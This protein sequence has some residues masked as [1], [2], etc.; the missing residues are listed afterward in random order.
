MTEKEAKEIIKK[1]EEYLDNAEMSNDHFISIIGSKD[2]IENITT[3]LEIIY[4][5]PEYIRNTLL[6]FPIKIGAIAGRKI[7]F[8]VSDK[9]EDNSIYINVYSIEGEKE[10]QRLANDYT[11][12]YNLKG[13]YTYE[14]KKWND[15]KM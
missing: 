1:I 12:D 15:N 4:Q 2:I 14:T 11:D 7:N 6:P 13:E 8:V 10:A 5:S 3:Y 9:I